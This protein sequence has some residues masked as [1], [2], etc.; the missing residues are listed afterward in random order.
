MTEED[1]NNFK[2]LS[3]SLKLLGDLNYLYLSIGSNDIG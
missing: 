1:G 3:D 2:I